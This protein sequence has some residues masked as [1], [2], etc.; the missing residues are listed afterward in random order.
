MTYSLAEQCLGI[1]TFIHRIEVSSELAGW[2][3]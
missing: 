2:N 3:L 1:R